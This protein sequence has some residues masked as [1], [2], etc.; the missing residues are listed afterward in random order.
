VENFVGNGPFRMTQW[1]QNQKLVVVRS[2]TYWDR[3]HVKLDEIDFEPIEATETEEHMFRTGQLDVTYDVPLSKLAS[4][5]KNSPDLVHTAPWCGVYFYRFNL[6]RKPLGDIRVRRALALAIDREQLVKDVTLAGE[7]PAYA[8]IPPNTAG[9]ISQY[10]LHSDIAEAKRL[11]AEAGFPDGRGFPHLDLSYNTFEKHRVIAEA[12]QEM[13]RRTLGIEVTLSNEEWK[14]YEA[15]QKAMNF[16]IQ[17]GGWLADYLDPHVFLDEWR[18]GG[19]NNFTHWGNPVY[20]H[21]LAT[22]LDAK[23]TEARYA[24]Y[25]RMEKIILDEVPIIPLFFYNQSRLIN[26][27][28]KNFRITPLDNYPWKFVDKDR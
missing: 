1:R 27:K 20:D 2:P 25:N 12:I 23:T 28:V 18:T 14:V 22:A 8:L 16:D 4:Y 7:E 11:L 9:Y 24:I 5:R 6:E 10:H 21:L 26:P 19:G 3:E 17:R 13:W 15:D